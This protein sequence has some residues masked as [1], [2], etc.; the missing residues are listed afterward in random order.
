M[1]QVRAPYNVQS[2]IDATGVESFDEALANMEAHGGEKTRGPNGIPGVG[3]RAYCEARSARSSNSVSA[4][5]TD[6]FRR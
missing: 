2:I 5:S 1:R 3:I 6:H 4:N